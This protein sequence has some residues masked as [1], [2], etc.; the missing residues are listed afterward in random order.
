[1]RDTITILCNKARHTIMNTTLDSL[2]FI[3]FGGLNERTVA[4][5]HKSLPL[6]FTSSAVMC[7]RQAAFVLKSH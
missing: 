5:E 1:M 7:M 6:G 4:I 3:K 2:H